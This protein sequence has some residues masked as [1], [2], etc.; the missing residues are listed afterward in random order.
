MVKT[1]EEDGFKDLDGD[2]ADGVEE[3]F[4]VSYALSHVGQ[5][6]EVWRWG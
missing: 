2:A 1:R 3:T 6:F 5:I 4:L